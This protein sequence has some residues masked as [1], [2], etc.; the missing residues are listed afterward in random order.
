MC[1]CTQEMFYSI[2]SFYF[3]SN[4]FKNLYLHV[5]DSCK[6]MN[7]FNWSNIFAENFVNLLSPLFCIEFNLRC[8]TYIQQKS[9][10]LIFHVNETH[11]R[12]KVI[13]SN[14]S[15]IIRITNFMWQPFAKLWNISWCITQL[16]NWIMY[17]IGQDKKNYMPLKIY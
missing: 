12:K 5:T 6:V 7:N 15:D 17:N 1:M 2:C 13:I 9:P 3:N 14:V 8:M 16:H 4:Y 11:T 10:S